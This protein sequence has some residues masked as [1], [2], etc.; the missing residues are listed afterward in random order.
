[1]ADAQRHKGYIVYQ[2]LQRPNPQKYRINYKELQI[3]RTGFHLLAFNK[4]LA[5]RFRHKTF[6]PLDG[7]LSRRFSDPS[8]LDFVCVFLVRSSGSSYMYMFSVLKL[9]VYTAH[10]TC[11]EQA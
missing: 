7:G 6:F 5:S 4:N 8:L 2:W 1:M 9:Q 3:S 10:H 11:Q